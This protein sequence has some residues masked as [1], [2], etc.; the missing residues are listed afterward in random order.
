MIGPFDGER[1]KCIVDTGTAAALGGSLAACAN[2]DPVSFSSSPQFAYG[3]ARDYPLADRVI[4]WVPAKYPDGNPNVPR[5]W[6]VATDCAFASVTSTGR[7]EVAEAAGYSAKVDTTGLAAGT[8]LALPFPRQL[9]C[10]VHR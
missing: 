10:R 3:V 9:G 6:Q 2:G 8:P 7:G 4:L 1:G 5:N